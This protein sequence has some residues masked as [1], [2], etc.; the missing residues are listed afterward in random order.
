MIY[1]KKHPSLNKDLINEDNITKQEKRRLISSGQRKKNKITSSEESYSIPT[2]NIEL[3]TPDEKVIGITASGVSASGVSASIPTNN[4]ELTTPDEKIIG[5]TVSGVSG[6]APIT[7]EGL[8]NKIFEK[9]ERDKW[10]LSSED[11]N[12]MNSI[13][14][15]SV[16]SWSYTPDD[17]DKDPIIKIVD[18]FSQAHSLY[19]TP[20]IP[21][22]RPNGK[23]SQKT[24][25]EY[26]YVGKDSSSGQWREESAPNGP[27]VI[28]S[29]FDK[30]RDGIDKI[31]QDKEMRKIFANSKF[32]VKNTTIISVDNKQTKLESVGI[33]NETIDDINSTKDVDKQGVIIFNF[34]QNM[35]NKNTLADF[36]GNKRKLMS[37]YFGITDNSVDKFT[38][39]GN[40]KPSK[41]DIDPK[42]LR[43]Q[44][45]VCK[46]NELDKKFFILPIDNITTYFCIGLG[47]EVINYKDTKNA[48][49]HVN[50]T[51][52]YFWKNNDKEIKDWASRTNPKLELANI[53][54]PLN[55]DIQFN[56]LGFLDSMNDSNDTIKR[57]NCEWYL[58]KLGSGDSFENE[59]VLKSLTKTDEYPTIKS[60]GEL[61]K[62]IKKGEL[63]WELN[64]YMQ[65]T[66]GGATNY[67]SADETMYNK[68]KNYLKDIVKENFKSAV[69]NRKKQVD[70]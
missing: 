12:K 40:F 16:T 56:G 28:N 23:I 41:R 18:I 43:W 57:S 70:I 5:I 48:K 35:I 29:I 66:S 50:G 44:S 34:I 25:L 11:I 13:G 27:F 14:N 19:F 26:S 20:Q 64:S 42:Y 30:W 4:I 59:P 36:D 63:N 65:L 32:K 54:D 47:S 61:D 55:K 67:Y 2:N 6:S 22:G 33:F 60:G 21:S 38:Y 31:I 45:T 53:L 58:I 10:D 3:T 51:Y 15:Q 52:F 49:K 69:L 7:I 46:Y 8:F 1:L 37:D 17:D 62:T 39:N 24:W 9:G 68:Y